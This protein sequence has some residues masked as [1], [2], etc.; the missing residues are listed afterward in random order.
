[1][2]LYFVSDCAFIMVMNLTVMDAYI[3][4]K[5][6]GS[7]YRHRETFSEFEHDLH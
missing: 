3:F 5:L 1:M 7:K 2:P 4:G 6:L